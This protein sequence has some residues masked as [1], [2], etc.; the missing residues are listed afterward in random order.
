MFSK[1]RYGT[2][3]SFVIS[4][5]KS[6]TMKFPSDEL[7]IDWTLSKNKIKLKKNNLGLIQQYPLPEVKEYYND[8]QFYTQHVVASEWFEK[9][10]QEYESGLWNP[11]FD[12]LI[13]RM[14]PQL[15]LLDVGCGAGWFMDY[16]ARRVN[17][18]NGIE[19]SSLAHQHAPYDIVPWIW[20]NKESF[21]ATCGSSYRSNN[22]ILMSLVLEHIPD[23]VSFIQQYIPYMGNEGTL[24]IVVPNDFSPLQE[25]LGTTHFIQDVHVNYFTTESLENVIY[26][27]LPVSD[28]PVKYKLDYAST[29]P[30]E[31][32]E[33]LGFH[34]IE[35][36]KLGAKCH[37]FRLLFEKF[38][39]KRAFWMYEKLFDKYGIGRE[40]VFTVKKV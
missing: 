24:T 6:V 32:F 33:L 3:K 1:N 12:Y 30:M 14:N 18:A 27:A 20:S 16:Y 2:N 10:R 36:G 23:P 4:R 25:W 21:N 22:N 19:P 9:E 38:L 26:A 8:D 5:A 35:N 29:F 37:K 40:L 15:P 39:Q 11:Y 13:S 17:V 7:P 31:L 34:Y 28:P